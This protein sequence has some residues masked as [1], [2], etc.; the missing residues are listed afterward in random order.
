MATVHIFGNSLAYGLYG[1]ES[2]WSNRLK[3][4]MTK[5]RLRGERPFVTVA[6]HAGPGNMLV[7][8]LE[9]G[10]IEANVQ[11]YRRGKQVGVFAVGS[12]ESCVLYAQGDAEPR[13]SL[14]AFRGD[15][16]RLTD[17][18][19]DLNKGAPNAPFEPIF[20]SAAPIDEEKA[21]QIW[22][23]DVFNNTRLAEYDAAIIG[24]AAAT[25]A[26]Y[27]DLWTGFD[28]SHMLATDA[29]HPN[30]AGSRYIYKK[31]SNVIFEALGLSNT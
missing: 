8:S 31:M 15:L 14:S 10:Q 6:N 9:S 5:R 17:V 29:I 13:R 3:Q 4:D 7:H 22:G 28:S 18:I 21:G 23:H 11:C 12:C 19:V 24:Y 27:V 1:L 16:S 26:R 2:D 25:G 20:M 30:R